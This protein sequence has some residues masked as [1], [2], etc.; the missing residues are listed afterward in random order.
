M[1][2][3]SQLALITLLHDVIQKMRV[4]EELNYLN[5]G[6]KLSTYT[7]PCILLYSMFF[8]PCAFHALFRVYSMRCSMRIQRVFVCVEPGRHS[9]F[10]PGDARRRQ[11]YLQ[12]CRLD[13]PLRGVATILAPKLAN[14]PRRH[15]R[16]LFSS[17]RSNYPI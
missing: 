6:G 13:N 1:G 7:N 11:H 9:W 8:I 2:L 16:R 14:E 4:Y 17:V 12:H 5:Y 15:G 10:F 3:V